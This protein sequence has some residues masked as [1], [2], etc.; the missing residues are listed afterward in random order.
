[1]GERMDDEYGCSSCFFYFGPHSSKASID[2][3]VGNGNS[4]SDKSVVRMLSK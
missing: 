3:A 1:M 4:D 2:T